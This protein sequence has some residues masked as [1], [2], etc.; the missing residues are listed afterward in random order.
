MAA[1]EFT[2]L[3]S[4]FCLWDV[5]LE[6]KSKCL[7]ASL[8]LPTLEKIFFGLTDLQMAEKR[9]MN[10]VLIFVQVAHDQWVGKC[11]ALLHMLKPLHQNTLVGTAS[12]TVGLWKVSQTP[13]S[14]KFSV[15]CDWV[16]NSFTT[17]KPHWGS[18]VIS[19]HNFGSCTDTA[20]RSVDNP[21]LTSAWHVAPKVGTPSR[22]LSTD[23]WTGNIPRS[24]YHSYLGSWKNWV[25]LE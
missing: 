6:L 7:F 22:H 10:S 20:L 12:F 8:C 25:I 5:T 3:A 15:P 19:R 11:V 24:G 13:N 17:L 1:D 23:K 4:L 9:L 18:M 16:G 2:D 14:I 21:F